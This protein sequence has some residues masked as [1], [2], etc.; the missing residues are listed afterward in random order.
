[1]VLFAA[2]LLIFRYILIGYGIFFFF[3]V[4][5]ITLHTTYRSRQGVRYVPRIRGLNYTRHE[6]QRTKKHKRAA[7]GKT[8]NYMSHQPSVAN[9][10]QDLVQVQNT[11]APRP[12]PPVLPPQG[13]TLI[14]HFLSSISSQ[15]LHA[16]PIPPLPGNRKPGGYP[17]Q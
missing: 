15:E 16:L 8:A 9:P 10:H 5:Y 12:P 3:K 7:E 6:T 4:T 11:P 13:S 2:S 14:L 1:M 17:S